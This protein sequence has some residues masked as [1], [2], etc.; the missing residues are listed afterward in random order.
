MDANTVEIQRHETPYEQCEGCGAAVDHAQRYCVECGH[1]RRHVRDPAARHLASATG[2]SRARATSSRPASGGRRRGAT[3]GTALVIGVIPLAIGLGVLVGRA[4]TA[5]D[6]KLIAALRAQRPEVIM[7]GSGSAATTSGAATPAATPAA[8]LSST[9]PLQSGYAVELQTLPSGTTQASV[10]SAEA[11]ATA[12]GAT[13]VGLIVQTDFKVVPAPPAGSYVIYAGAFKSRS[14]AE[15]ELAKLRGK[16][17]GAKVIQVSPLSSGGG[18]VLAHTKYG[19]AH[20]VTGFHPTHI[21]LQQDGQLVKQ[22]QQKYNQNYVQSQR[23]LPD[24]IS[25]P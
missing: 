1:H 8:T 13:D 7:S 20:Q 14:A 24:Q 4:S 16:F 2:R 6:S 25:V 9:F 15:G 18:Q 11:T 19:V 21:Q 22:I 23:G 10:S 3:L 5:N 17:V 12:E